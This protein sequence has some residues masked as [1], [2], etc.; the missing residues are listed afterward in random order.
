MKLNSE[1]E[2]KFLEFMK[3]Y[4]KKYSKY[5]YN[6]IMENYQHGE[7]SSYDIFRQIYSYLGI[8]DENTDMYK[9]FLN[10]VLDNF[11]INTDVL[12]IA[13][14]FFP[15]VSKYI[16]DVQMKTKKGTVTVYDPKLIVNCLNNVILKKEEFNASTNIDKYK[17]VYG[18][19]PC[20]ATEIFAKRVCSEKKDFVI[21]LCGCVHLDNTFFGMYSNPLER[22]KEY[23][24]NIIDTNK[25][26]NCKINIKYLE[27]RYDSPYPIIIGK[28]M[29]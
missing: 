1:E 4:G 29:E 14:G 10:I 24:F 2:V 12:E 7:F 26:E 20:E 6:Y 25:S 11:N 27:K 28:H 5:A 15:V 17:L 8:L 19:F 21:G 13:G 9:G 22:W 18:F 16:D 23:V 3:L